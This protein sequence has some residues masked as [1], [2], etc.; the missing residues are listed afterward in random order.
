MKYIDYREKLEEFF[1]VNTRT[2][3]EDMQQYDLNDVNLQTDD[4]T[5]V[6]YGYKIHGLSTANGEKRS[7]NTSKF[8]R[9]LREAE[10]AAESLLRSHQASGCDSLVIYKAIKMIG[11]SQPPLASSFVQCEDE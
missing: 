6:K 9:T 2:G 10:R 4:L 7:A 3:A 1:N 8:Y 5:P 11:Y